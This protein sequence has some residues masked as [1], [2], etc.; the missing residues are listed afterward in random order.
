MSPDEFTRD[1][2]TYA[3]FYGGSF[4]WSLPRGAR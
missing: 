2:G 4:F 3:Y 1:L